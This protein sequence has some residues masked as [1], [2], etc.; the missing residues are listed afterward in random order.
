MDLCNLS[1]ADF[2]SLTRHNAHIGNLMGAVAEVSWAIMDRAEES[3]WISFNGWSAE[4]KAADWMNSH[5]S[6][7]NDALGLHAV[8]LENWPDYLGMH[9]HSGA[10]CSFMVWA[11]N[12]PRMHLPE[13][14]QIFITLCGRGVPAPFALAF[15]FIIELH[16]DICGLPGD[17][18]ALFGDAVAGQLCEPHAG[19]TS[20][21][22]LVLH[23]A[24]AV[25]DLPP[26]PETSQRQGS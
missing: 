9:G 13:S 15:I 16:T 11:F 12:Q 4:E 21:K 3:I 6:A 8:K 7:A 18:R 24:S 23:Q 2:A 26:S 10:A 20:K 17:I 19:I 22:S 1:D 14:L 5:N 25:N